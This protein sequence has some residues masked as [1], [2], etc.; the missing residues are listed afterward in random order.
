MPIF[1]VLLVLENHPES[2]HLENT[3]SMDAG[4]FTACGRDIFLHPP[5]PL[6]EFHLIQCNPILDIS[7][8]LIVS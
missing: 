8:P 2:G 7:P 3:I 1:I 5:A 6:E 4:I